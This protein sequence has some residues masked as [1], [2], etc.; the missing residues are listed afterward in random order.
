MFTKKTI[1]R[2]E[3]SNNQKVIIKTVPFDT[4]TGTVHKV[5]FI[6]DKDK[7]IEINYGWTE[8]GP[9]E[10]LDQPVIIFF[11]SDD[12][13]INWC[14]GCGLILSNIFSALSY[15]V[16]NK[17]GVEDGEDTR[18]LM[19]HIPNI[20][21]LIID[22]M[23]RTNQEIIISDIEYETITKDVHYPYAILHKMNNVREDEIE[24][25]TLFLPR[26]DDKTDKMKMYDGKIIVKTDSIRIFYGNEPL[27]GEDFN[28]FIV[29]IEFKERV[30]KAHELFTT[31]QKIV[32]DIYNT[33]HLLD[34]YNYRLSMVLLLDGIYSILSTME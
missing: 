6:E 32:T 2:Y 18:K 21:Q 5:F 33:R 9:D 11:H 25:T 13:Y 26:D 3:G 31:L 28:E 29:K 8:E 20:V 14:Y 30:Y 22:F 1:V 16:E 7:G 19:N 12:L 4:N 17:D 10:L 34:N 24:Q 27:L 23:K 15:M